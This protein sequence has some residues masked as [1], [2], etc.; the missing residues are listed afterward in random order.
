M[1]A[2]RV[3][4]SA[5]LEE[6]WRSDALRGFVVETLRRQDDFAPFR[7]AWDVDVSVERLQVSAKVTSGSSPG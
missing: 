5:R 1:T 4:Q 2:S 3:F 7:D 6:D